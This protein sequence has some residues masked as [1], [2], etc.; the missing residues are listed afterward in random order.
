MP[1]T[2]TH[3]DLTL[4]EMV[5]KIMRIFLNTDWFVEMDAN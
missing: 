4:D 5:S 1:R 3:W 2:K